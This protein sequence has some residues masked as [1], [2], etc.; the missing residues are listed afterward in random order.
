ME[1][2]SPISLISFSSAR[3]HRATRNFINQLQSPSGTISKDNRSPLSLP[4]FSDSLSLYCMEEDASR[5]VT[6]GRDTQRGLIYT[7]VST[8]TIGD[9]EVPNIIA[10][11][12]IYIVQH[13]T[14]THAVFQFVPHLHVTHTRRVTCASSRRNDDFATPSDMSRPDIFLLERENGM[15]RPREGR[16]KCAAG[17]LHFARHTRGHRPY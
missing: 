16:E 7:R 1:I 6:R 15:P 3:F 2:I 5:C 14:V 4:F 12:P 11:E 17:I 13:C 10:L 9:C 8:I